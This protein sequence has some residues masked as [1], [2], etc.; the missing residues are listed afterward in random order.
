MAVPH[1]FSDRIIASREIPARDERWGELPDRCR[2]ELR[3][4]LAAQGIDQL[5]SHQA[6]FFRR[7]LDRENLVITTGT[8]SGKSLAYLLPVLQQVLDD[9]S[10]RAMLLFPT[11]ALAQDQLRGLLS[12][13][14]HLGSLRVQAGVYDGDTP[15]VE[16]SRIRE[17]C[18]LVLTNPDMLNAAWLPN[19]GRRGFSHVFK[20]LRFLV[21]DEMH[22]YRGAFGSHVANLVRRLRR[23]CRHYGSAPQILGSSATIANPTELAEAIFHVPFGLVSE[24][25]SP[26]Q[27]KIVH[28]WQP[29]IVEG[30]L[31]RS[32]VQEMSDLLPAL[33]AKRR[34]T[35]AFCRSRKET[36]VVLKET[37]DALLVV[38]GGHDESR[39]VAG[40]RGGYTPE[41]RRQ[42]ERDLL[43]GR[44]IAVVSTNA[45]ELGIDIGNLETVAQAGFPGT[46]AS[47]WQQIGRAGRRG[48]RAEAFV[49]LRMAPM[50]QFLA[51]NPDWLMTQSAEHA[52]IDRDNLMIQLAHIRA[53][54]AELP[55]TLDDA[56]SFPDLG[57]AVA[58]LV[59]AG[60]LRQVFGSY[61]WSGPAHPAGDFSLRNMDRDRF[62]IVNVATGTTLTEMDRPQTYHE[63][64]WRAVYLHDG[65]QYMV[66]ELDLVGHVAKVRPVEQNFY[67]EPDI[68]TT[69]EVL[70]LQKERDLLRTRARFGDVR[71]E[72]STIGYKMLE[73][74]N[75]Q[76]LGYEMLPERLVTVLETEGL[77][78][79]VP[80]NVMQ[81]LAER[82]DDHLRG[83]IHPIL[84][85][86]RMTAMAEGTDLRGTSFHYTDEESGRTRT[87]IILYDGH[88]GGLGFSQKIEEQLEGV[89]ERS[90]ELVAQCACRDGCPA[91]VGDWQLEK[92]LVSWSLSNLFQESAPPSALSRRRPQ[93]IVRSKRR[94]TLAELPDRWPEFVAGLPDRGT[95]GA[96]F[97]K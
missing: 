26:S 72:D 50:D 97:L 95:P 13:V 59:E 92:G 10:S 79:H 32:V 18:H 51:K 2:P 44:L 35:I 87:C 33:V 1:R 85:C 62:K 86:A 71:V 29:P 11:K 7:A 19:H 53:A 41:E 49:I 78:F 43:E 3:A 16:R 67:T 55:L 23:I 24:D 30:D 81:V 12:Y 69:I 88:P 73:F 28:F 15:P 47:F 84:S 83:M 27:G 52:V 77:W 61:H 75:H 68:R 80:T 17:K 66:D 93:P 14:E 25:G 20:N 90:L 5:Y 6:E 96:A 74:H 63:A 48:R 22:T 39:L 65:L 38:D 60:E 56:Q 8:A 31:R 58:V 46:R 54:A 89:L 21:V 82:D 94:F 40:Y 37:R 9:P 45:L 70:I 42:V 57:E 34:R 36:E 4:A 64:H 91:C 76:N